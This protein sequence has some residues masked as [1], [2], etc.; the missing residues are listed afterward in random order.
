MEYAKLLVEGYNQIHNEDSPW[1]SLEKEKDFFTNSI[2]NFFSEDG[3]SNHIRDL[4]RKVRA[5]MKLYTEEGSDHIAQMNFSNAEKVYSEYLEGMASFVHEVHDFK[6]TTEGVSSIESTMKERITKAIGLDHGFIDMLE[7]S[8]NLNPKKEVNYMEATNMLENM[9]D[10]IDL[11]N[12]QF[13]ICSFVNEHVDTNELTKDSSKL[14]CE[15]I[16]YYWLNSIQ[17][18]L[19]GYETLYEAVM[20][21]NKPKNNNEFVLL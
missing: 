5:N 1:E 2:K 4:Y 21:T 20:H 3:E 14:I 9:V 6:Y 12:D 13:N 8:D 18:M 10:F 17:N 16:S 11:M 15:S 19:K 7:S